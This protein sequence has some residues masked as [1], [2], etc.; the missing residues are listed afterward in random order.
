MQQATKYVMILDPEGERSF[1]MGSE[2]RH[3]TLTIIEARLYNREQDVEGFKDRWRALAEK[4]DAVLKDEKRKV[5]SPLSTLRRDIR[6]TWQ[7]D[8]KTLGL[9]DDHRPRDEE[10]WSAPYAMC[11]DISKPGTEDVVRLAAFVQKMR[12]ASERLKGYDAFGHNR[13]TPK[14]VMSV[15]ATAFRAVAVTQRIRSDTDAALDPIYLPTDVQPE[16]IVREVAR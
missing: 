16:R 10:G 9:K 14:D 11:F 12:K 2:Y 4:Y 8:K 6:L 5:Y 15:M 13:M 1:G 7:Q 3:P